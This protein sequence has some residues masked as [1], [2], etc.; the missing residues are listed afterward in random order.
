MTIPTT[1][2]RGEPVDPHDLSPG[3]RV[4][5]TAENRP[6]PLIEGEVTGGLDEWGKRGVTIARA[7]DGE[8]VNVH[9]SPERTFRRLERGERQ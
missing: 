9:P 5:V 6:G 7:S 2:D 4:R 8:R 3:D 1:P